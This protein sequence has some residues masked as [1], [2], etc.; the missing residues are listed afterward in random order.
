[1][2]Q[3][4]EERRCAVLLEPAGDLMQ[5]QPGD[6]DGQGLV[7]PE[8]GRGPEAQDEAGRDD[9]GHTDGHHHSE[10]TSQRM[11]FVIVSQFPF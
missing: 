8:R 7:Q 9:D 2:E 1:M 6:V 11:N 4:I 5:R 10:A 3:V